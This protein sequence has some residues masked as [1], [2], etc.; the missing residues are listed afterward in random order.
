M[1]RFLNKARL[2]SDEARKAAEDLVVLR[3]RYAH[4]RGKNPSVDALT[5]ITK[6]HQLLDGTVSLLKEFD[7]TEEMSAHTPIVDEV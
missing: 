7:I 3:N 5:A 1:V 2:L 6:L 4:A